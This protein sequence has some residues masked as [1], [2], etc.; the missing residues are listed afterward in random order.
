MILYNL[1]FAFVYLT[2]VFV[3]LVDCCWLDYPANEFFHLG[4]H[5]IYVIKRNQRNRI[6]GYLRGRAVDYGNNRMAL[7]NETSKPENKHLCQL[8]N[9]KDFPCLKKNQKG[10]ENYELYGFCWN[11]LSPTIYDINS[12]NY[13][14]L[15]HRLCTT[16]CDVLFS[17]EK[18][19]MC[20]VETSHLWLSKWEPSFFIIIT[21]AFIFIPKINY[22]LKHLLYEWSIVI[23]L[24]E[25]FFRIYK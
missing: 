22:F 10:L 9:N 6:G 25:F 17:K 18:I 2:K 16:K 7:K 1:T 15:N 24:T 11:L 3:G 4:H 14:K 23:I 21:Y 20:F 5:S 13:L 8:D 19:K 12:F